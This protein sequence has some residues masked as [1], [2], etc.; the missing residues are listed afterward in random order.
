MRMIQKSGGEKVGVAAEIPYVE[1]LAEAA[2]L[3]TLPLEAANGRVAALFRQLYE[4]IM[5]KM[6]SPATSPGRFV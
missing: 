5:E 1:E 2:R 4:R 3:S 6:D